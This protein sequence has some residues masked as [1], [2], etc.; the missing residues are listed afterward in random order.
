MSD[1]IKLYTLHTPSHREMCE[2]F[3]VANA[4]DA[5]FDHCVVFK[6]EQMCESGS[7]NTSGFAETCWVKLDALA[8]IPVGTKACYVDADCILFPG[9]SDWCETWLNG[10]ENDSISLGN[11]VK[12][13]CMGTIVWLQTDKTAEFWRFLRQL[14]FMVGCHD[15]AALHGL[16]MNSVNWP[17]PISVLP[18]TIFANW[19]TYGD[20]S[21]K[22]WQ[23]GQEFIIPDDALCWHA[24]FVVGVEN[25]QTML[26]MVESQKSL[27]TDKQICA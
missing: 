21:Q 20:H 23:P 11:D 17:L 27:L 5:G 13:W 8:T 2:R 25:K 6:S 22:I 24:N 16:R 1:E 3:V 26:E 4:G 18:N 9:L 10:Q 12:E 15:Q 14:A 19:A 7:Y